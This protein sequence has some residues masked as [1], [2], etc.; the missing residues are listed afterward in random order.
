[1]VDYH[2]DNDS[3]DDDDYD[4]ADDEDNDNGGDDGGDVD[5]Y[6]LYDM[7]SLLSAHQSI[8]SVI[9]FNACTSIILTTTTPC[10]A[11]ISIMHLLCKPIKDLIFVHFPRQLLAVIIII[12]VSIIIIITNSIIIIITNS[13]IIIITIS[14]AEFI[15]LCSVQNLLF[16]MV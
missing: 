14:N 13:I 2:L 6:E 8:E 12:T 4:Y 3:D 15:L 11:A 5:Y 7:M 10:H 9:H 1:M 16:L